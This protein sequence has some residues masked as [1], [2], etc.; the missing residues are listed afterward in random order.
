MSEPHEARSD[1]LL[2]I[3]RSDLEKI[4]LVLE[5]AL[6]EG[7]GAISLNEK[8]IDEA[9]MKEAKRILKFAEGA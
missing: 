5:K 8:M 6:E 7:R 9:V 4:L 2:P 1:E 3:R